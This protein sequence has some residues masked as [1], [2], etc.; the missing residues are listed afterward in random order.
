MLKSQE[1]GSDCVRS[2]GL[3][4]LRILNSVGRESPIYSMKI[5][6]TSDGVL[7]SPRLPWSALRKLIFQQNIIRR[8]STQK[9]KLAG[10]YQP[11]TV[12]L[13]SLKCRKC[14]SPRSICDQ[15]V[16]S[17]FYNGEKS[18]RM[19]HLPSFLRDCQQFWENPDPEAPPYHGF[20]PLLYAVML[21]G[22]SYDE[23]K[24]IGDQLADHGLTEA[25]L[26]NMIEAWV[27]RLSW[28][29]RNELCSLRIQCLLFMTHQL[30][31]AAPMETVWTNAGTA[32]RMAM[33]MGLH[34]DPSE[35]PNISIFDGEQRRRLWATVVEMDLQASLAVGCPPMVR[36]GDYSCLPP[37]N[38]DDLDFYEEMTEYP[39]SK[40][41]EEWTDCSCQVLLAKL[42][43]SNSY[44][45]VRLLQ[46]HGSK[47]QQV[48]SIKITSYGSC[49]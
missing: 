5:L 38:V 32:V 30:H 25:A 4:C 8:R 28:R 34:H 48:S 11:S 45:S 26:S 46:E 6:R 9:A 41:I 17:Y 49:Q 47:V 42:V 40:P 44:S 7:G 15:L 1:Y 13:R 29:N 33:T 16:H 19:L 12:L 23:S 21:V 2:I 37:A 3:N 35:F 43:G 36:E 22:S 31:L 24:V 18:L 39:T 27:N 20:M 14:Y 10:I